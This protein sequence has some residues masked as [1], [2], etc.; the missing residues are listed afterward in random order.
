MMLTVERRGLGHH[1]SEGFKKAAQSVLE[2]K[3]L[4]TLMRSVNATPSPSR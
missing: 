3:R 4:H 2:A 1:A